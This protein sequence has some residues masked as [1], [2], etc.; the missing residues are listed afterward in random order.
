[1]IAHLAKEQLEMLGLN[2]AFPA[3]VTNCGA[4]MRKAF[5]NI[6][7][8]DFLRGG[9]HL[10]HNDVTVGFT[11]LRNNEHNPAQTEARKF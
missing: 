2:V 3:I 8:W 4:N 6:L 5:K 11:T 1:M 10:I 9:F 7:K